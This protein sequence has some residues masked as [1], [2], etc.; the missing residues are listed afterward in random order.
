M[1]ETP[2]SRSQ[3][4]SG[5][6]ARLALIGAIERATAAVVEETVDLRANR[7]VDCAEH[8]RKKD[9]SLLD[10]TRRSR[11]LEETDLSGDVRAALQRLRSAIIE[12]QMV[13]RLHLNAARQIAN[14][15]IDVIVQS[16]SDRT[17]TRPH[18]ALQRPK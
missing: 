12:N 18:P 3:E 8:R 1:T 16:E 5:P 17:Y 2:A 14:I 13:L 15:L 6:Q 10:L 7:I 4:T 11:S 9:M